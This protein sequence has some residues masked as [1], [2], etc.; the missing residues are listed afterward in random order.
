[1]YCKCG[2][3]FSSQTT[4]P[5]SPL[6]VMLSREVLAI[7]SSLPALDLLPIR[8]VTGS[9]K[10][11]D[12][13]SFIRAIGKHYNQRYAPNA[14]NL[15]LPDLGLA[16]THVQQTATILSNWPDSFQIFLRQFA[17]L[18]TAEPQSYFRST[19]LSNLLRALLKFDR[20]SPLAIETRNLLSALEPTVWD[21]RH[22]GPYP[23][24]Q[25]STPSK[26]SYITPAAKRLNV[27]RKT[28]KQL[29]A[30]GK[31]CAIN[32]PGGRRDFTLIP[33]SA[34]SQA[35]SSLTDRISHKETARLLGI[36]SNRLTQLQ[37]AEL[38]STGKTGASC[39]IYY[40]HKQ[41]GRFLEDFKVCEDQHHCSDSRSLKNIAKYITSCDREFVAII[42]AL[43][44]RDLRIVHYDKALGTLAGM[45]VSQSEFAEWRAQKRI[46]N[47]LVDEA[48]QCLGLKQEV[49]YHLVRKGLI[50]SSREKVGRRTCRIILQK[51]LEEFIQKYISAVEMAKMYGTSPQ[52]LVYRLFR[53]SIYP[54]TG[55]AIDGGRQYFYLRSQVRYSDNVFGNR[56]RRSTN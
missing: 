32:R 47:L 42:R 8:T 2:A 46:R 1:M 49:A 15:P 9:N 41:L 39:T 54:E 51:D 14:R 24:P 3:D 21:K 45:H 56:A 44:N 11:E 20:T 22:Y 17:Q 52:S 31:L 18:D 55:P 29:I 4:S 38:F 25:V 53:K 28:V 36:S 40:S 33:T 19:A 30:D 13:C 34:L 6:E 37:E 48:A 10:F 26:F 7:A 16:R 35:Q 27:S 23:K 5:A 12:A 50:K 43:M